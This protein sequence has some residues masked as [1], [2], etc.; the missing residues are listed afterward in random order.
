VFADELYEAIRAQL[1]VEGSIV[2]SVFSKSGVAA[3]LQEHQTRKNR[4]ALLGYWVT[5]ALF[6]ELLQ[7]VRP[8]N[9]TSQ[10]A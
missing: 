7:Q 4:L 2:A 3:V 1:S 8:R 6:Q 5:Q 9:G 10:V